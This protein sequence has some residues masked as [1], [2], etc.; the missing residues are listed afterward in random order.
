MRVALPRRPPLPVLFAL[1]GCLAAAQVF[2]APEA[3]LA[4]KNGDIENPAP[5]PRKHTT[6]VV[7]ADRPLPAGEWP[8]LFAAVRLAL[9]KD[10]GETEVLDSEPSLMRADTMAPGTLTPSPVVVVFLRGDC[11][12]APP[13]L[14]A[15][16]GAPLGWVFEE[17]GAE[18]VIQPFVYVD[19]TTIGEVLGERALRMSKRERV[20]AMASA[21]A[22]VILHEWIHIATQNAGHTA[23]GVTKAAFGPD[24]LLRN[25][26]RADAHAQAAGKSR[27]VAQSGN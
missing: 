22:Q 27:A 10:G 1:L 8:A 24:D 9:A 13:S 21:I 5:A 15:A 2:A 4:P 16:F 11:K 12:L 25:Y 14:P 20:K 3:G 6:L 17:R 23:S 7:F 26:K 19:C 18:P